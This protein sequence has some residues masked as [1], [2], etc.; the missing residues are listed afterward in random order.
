[1]RTAQYHLLTSSAPLPTTKKIVA[2]W[3]LHVNY[4][5][6]MQTSDCVADEVAM[7]ISVCLQQ[8]CLLKYILFYKTYFSKSF[9]QNIQDRIKTGPFK[10]PKG[11][12]VHLTNSTYFE[13]TQPCLCFQLQIYFSKSKSTIFLAFSNTV[14][15]A[16]YSDYG[17]CLLAVS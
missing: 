16:Y 15:C 1:M 7:Y 4:V 9:T 10:G 14:L 5:T 2:S 6:S 12:D 13:M 17:L 8:C 3:I 11:M